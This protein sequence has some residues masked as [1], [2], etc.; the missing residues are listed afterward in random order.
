[1][2]DGKWKTFAK[3]TTSGANKIIRFPAISTTA[4]RLKVIKASDFPSL[5]QISAG[6]HAT[7]TKG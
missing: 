5:W 2:V 6:Q 4:L 7:R 1:M 3:G